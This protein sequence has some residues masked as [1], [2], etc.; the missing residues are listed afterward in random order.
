MLKRVSD[1][2]SSVSFAIFDMKA[3]ILDLTATSFPYDYRLFRA[4]VDVCPSV[5][6][7]AS[8][9][10]DYVDIAGDQ[11]SSGLIDGSFVRFGLGKMRRELKAVEYLLNQ[12]RVLR[13]IA[14][15][16]VDVIHI[17]WLPFLKSYPF[18]DFSFVSKL[19]SFGVPLVYTVHNV[20]PHNRGD[21][22]ID[23]YRR[24]YSAMDGLICHTKLARDRLVREFHVPPDKIRVIPHGPID[25]LASYPSREDARTKLGYGEG[26]GVAL[27]FGNLHPYKGFE[28]LLSSWKHLIS[29]SRNVRLVIAGRGHRPYADALSHLIRSTGLEGFVDTRFEYI[30]DREL[31]CH[32]AAADVILYPYKDIT[33]SG[34]LLTALAQR[35]A[36]IATRVGGFIETI[37]DGVSGLL[38]DYGD[39]VALA[40]A[41]RGVLTDA[42]Y[43]QRLESGAQRLV[44]TEYRWSHIARRTVEFYDDLITGA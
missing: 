38:V 9:I 8:G 39:D 17:Q 33:Q 41:I 19:K 23:V 34:A 37:E 22:Y 32:I 7:M 14:K 25:L 12:R 11:F 31:A 28:F 30:P 16:G 5:K 10:P 2:D 40:E 3:V 26:Q 13:Y 29:S 6:L 44:E 43:R 4:L 20:L 27:I 42:N 18:F 24:V 35:K 1:T 21:R 36:V 15:E